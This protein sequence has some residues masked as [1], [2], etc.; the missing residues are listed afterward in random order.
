VRTPCGAV[1]FDTRLAQLLVKDRAELRQLTNDD[2][3]AISGIAEMNVDLATETS[4][5]SLGQRL[6]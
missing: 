4:V 2:L 1:A 3:P 5:S 6:F